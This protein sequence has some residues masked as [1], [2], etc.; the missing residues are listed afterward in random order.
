[1][2]EA[3]EAGRVEWLP[4]VDGIRNSLLDPGPELLKVLKQAEEWAKAG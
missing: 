1:M 3:P 2:S 4:V